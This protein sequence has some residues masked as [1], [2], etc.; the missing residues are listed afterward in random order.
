MT[1]MGRWPNK[2]RPAF[3]GSWFRLGWAAR[4][5]IP[6]RLSSVSASSSSSFSSSSS[7]SRIDDRGPGRNGEPCFS[8]RMH[9]SDKPALCE[10]EGEKEDAKEMLIFLNSVKSFLW[11][12]FIALRCAVSAGNPQQK[13]CIDGTFVQNMLRDI[14][15][16][17]PHL[18]L[19]VSAGM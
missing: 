12:S 3:H 18:C 16:S 11:F 1:A 9:W 15:K 2:R 8:W 5:Q 14:Y 17:P 19:N 4:Y 10:E 7:K 13:T 6:G